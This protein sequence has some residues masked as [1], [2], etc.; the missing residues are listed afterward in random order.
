MNMLGFS[1]YILVLVFSIIL[2]IFLPLSSSDLEK[3]E[4]YM[5]V[6]YAAMSVVYVIFFSL[7]SSGICWQS[8]RLRSNQLYWSVLLPDSYKLSGV[9]A[10]LKNSS[11]VCDIRRLEV[12]CH[13]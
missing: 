12:G 9:L 5:R 4:I 8:V 10:L 13:M 2:M 6:E 7:S 1:M 11:C 3:E